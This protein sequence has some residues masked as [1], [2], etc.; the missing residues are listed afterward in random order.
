MVTATPW[1]KEDYWE[2]FTLTDEDLE[3]FYQ[4]M[5]EKETPLS[6]EDLARALIRERIRQ[7][8]RRIEERWQSS[9]AVYMPKE[10]YQVG[11]TLVFPALN[12]MQGEVIGIREGY[13]PEQGKFEVIRVRLENGQEKE[14]AAGLANHVLNQPPRLDEVPIFQ[15]EW[16]WE[17]YGQ[18][19]TRQ[20]DEALTQQPGFIRIADL[21]FREELLVPIEERHLILAD[22]VLD[23]AGG[24]PLNTEDILKE[25]D[26]PEDLPKRLVLFS[27]ARALQEDP[28]FDEVGPAGTIRWFLRRMEPEAIWQPPMHLDYVPI[29]YD[30]EILP[31]ELR[32]LERRLHD[33][34]S[35]PPE[36]DIGEVESIEVPLIYPHWRVGSLPLDAYLERLFPR[37][38][39]A[40]RVYFTFVDAETGRR[41]P[42]WVVQGHR[43]VYGLRD[44]Y[45]EKKVIPGARVRVMRTSQPDEILVSTETRRMIREWI[46]TV[47]VDEKGRLHIGLENRP[48]GVRYDE[49]MAFL[50]PDPEA[51]DRVWKRIRDER[52]PFEELVMQVMREL[53][54]LT[55]G[56]HVHAAELY[57]A[58][59]LL[60]RTPPGPIFALLVSRPWFEYEGNLYFRLATEVAS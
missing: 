13:H 19:I 5:L 32:E 20:I 37:A 6:A 36:E 18:E 57:A 35:P 40:Q 39:Q 24:G 54:R 60:R 53:S 45:Q 8:Q 59:N 14:F 38:Y 41:F 33:E 7:E 49:H 17:H 26:L 48:I 52:R 16:V 47:R 56:G 3:F 23:L 43:F 34:H 42:G 22:A 1:V 44:W 46:R 30:P 25:L 2:Q 55:P 10:R 50:V 28:R 12:W 58:M 11:Q 27:L 15:P 51:L 4:Y 29:P 21:W 9:Q 31:E